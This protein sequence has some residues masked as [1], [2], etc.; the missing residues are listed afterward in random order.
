M[1]SRP[2]YP[3][4]TIPRYL[5]CLKQESRY[6]N[7]GLEMYLDGQLIAGSLYF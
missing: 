4:R 5:E 7:P 2:K 1:R 3:V 6:K